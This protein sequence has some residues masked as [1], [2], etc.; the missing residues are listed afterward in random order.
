MFEGF[1]H[2]KKMAVLQNTFIVR[3]NSQNAIAG[4]PIWCDEYQMLDIAGPT[5][6]IVVKLCGY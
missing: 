6:D 2:P 3:F 4:G 5:K 1:Q